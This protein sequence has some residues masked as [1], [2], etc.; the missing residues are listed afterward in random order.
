[1]NLLVDPVLVQSFNTFLPSLAIVTLDFKG[2]LI[3]G[4][5]TMYPES[6]QKT[7]ICLDSFNDF[8]F[9]WWQKL[10]KLPQKVTTFRDRLIMEDIAILS[11]LYPNFEP[12]ISLKNDTPARLATDYLQSWHR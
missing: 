10:L 1:M 8:E 3:L 11:D 7:R 5:V 6:P 2:R 4:A 9:S 12:K